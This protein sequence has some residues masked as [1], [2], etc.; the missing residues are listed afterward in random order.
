MALLSGTKEA[1]LYDILKKQNREKDF[2]KEMSNVS[3][4]V[5]ITMG[6]CYYGGNNHNPNIYRNEK[7]FKT[8][9][10]I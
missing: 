4:L 5:N 6:N 1:Y 9:T 2:H 8:K 7:T 3:F 10:L